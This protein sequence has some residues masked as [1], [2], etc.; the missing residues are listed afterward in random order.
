MKTSTTSSKSKYLFLA[1]LLPIMAEAKLVGKVHALKGD[2]FLIRD[3]KTTTLKKDMDIEEG[4]QVM[5]GDDASATVGDFY[6]RRYNLS[7]GS[8]LVMNDR[9]M[10]LLKGGLWSQSLSQKANVSVATANML[11]ASYQGEFIATYDA[12]TKKSQLTVIAGEVDVA[13]PMEPAF[14]YAVLAGQFSHATPDIDEGYPR[15]PT[16]LGYES[17]MKAVAMFPGVKSMDAG[18]AQAQTSSRAIASVEAVAEKKG[19]IIFMKTVQSSARTPASADGEAQKYFLKSTKKAVRSPK[20]ALSSAKVRVIGLR[21]VA[22][23]SSR[24]PASTHKIQS[25]EQAPSV[26]SSDFLKSYEQH[27]RQQPKNSQEVQRLIDDL[28]SY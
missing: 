22:A 12:A 2:A 21:S 15:A 14:R 17:L 16:K 8:N 13:S 25:K 4:S 20:Q 28:K 9:S 1:L 11:M 27:Q 19:E 23:P 26:N 3:G 5:V 18:V 6:D 7:S 24:K 10:T